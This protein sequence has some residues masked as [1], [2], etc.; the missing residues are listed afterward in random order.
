MC[1][2][3]EAQGSYWKALPLPPLHGFERGKGT[4]RKGRLRRCSYDD[5]DNL[6][7]YTNC[8]YSLTLSAA[9]DGFSFLQD[10]DCWI[11]LTFPLSPVS[12]LGQAKTMAMKGS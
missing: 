10:Q 5:D 11:K 4:N 1:A 7:Y 12:H 9:L 8:Q 3:A 6:L 2:S